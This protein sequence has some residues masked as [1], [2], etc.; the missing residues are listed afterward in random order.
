M[1]KEVLGPS[2]ESTVEAGVDEKGAKSY[3]FTEFLE[4]FFPRRKAELLEESLKE[5]E[6]PEDYVPLKTES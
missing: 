4:T 2:Q 3:T 1:D 5:R 6:A